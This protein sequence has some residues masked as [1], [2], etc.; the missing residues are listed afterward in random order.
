M[1]LKEYKKLVNMTEKMCDE[2]NVNTEVT[3]QLMQSLKDNLTNHVFY[4]HELRNP[5]KVVE[6]YLTQHSDAATI[7]NKVKGTLDRIQEQVE[8][9][10]T[11]DEP[12]DTPN[13]DE[14]QG[15]T[16]DEL[17]NSFR[18]ILKNLNIKDEV[19]EDFITL[20]E[21]ALMMEITLGIK[22]NP[23]TIIDIV[24]MRHNGDI[25][26]REP[27]KSIEDWFFGDDDFYS[28]LLGL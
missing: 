24:T 19:A 6:D 26:K 25:F 13:E 18:E 23:Q 15:Q 22:T 28:V 4:G 2:L 9:R 17:S 20:V 11:P 10:D 1:E 5:S 27:A 8:S 14:V 21:C 12:Q 7:E 16:V 3:N